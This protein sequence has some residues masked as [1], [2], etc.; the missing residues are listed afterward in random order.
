MARELVTKGSRFYCVSLT[1]DICK[2]PIGASTPPIPYNIIGEFSEATG[3]SPNITSN[4][5]PVALHDST[6]IPTVKGD[7]PGTAKG[8]KSGTV[9]KRVQH[10]GKSGTVTFNGQQAIRV[11]DRVYM[12]DKNTIGQV[13][14]RGPGPDEAAMAA[15]APTLPPATPTFEDKFN[16]AM[17]RAATVVRTGEDWLTGQIGG[18]A[19]T[20]AGAAIMAT[21][22]AVSDATE[23][24]PVKEWKERVDKDM[25]EAADSNGGSAMGVA[26]SLSH[27]ALEFIPT[28]M[29]DL[30]PGGGR[31]ASEAGKAAR[32]AKAA[33]RAERAAADA[34]KAAAEAERVAAAGRAA[35]GVT[36]L[37]KETPK[38]PRM[39]KD[40]GTSSGRGKKKKNNKP[41]KCC[42]KN[43]AP[44]GKSASS[45]HPVHFGTGEEVLV[46]T[47]FVLEGAEPIAWTRTYRSGSETEDWGLL[48]AR[49]GS[50]YTSS[51]HSC[52]QGIVYS[53]DSGRA[54]RLPPLAVGQTHDSREEGFTLVR[55][56]T[57]QFQL[58]WRDG[59]IDTFRQVADGWLPH[60][61]DG[62]NAMLRPQ[63]AQRTERFELSRSAGRDG[64][65]L[66]VE[67]TPPGAAGPLLLRVRGDDGLTLEAMAA[68]QPAPRFRT[69]ADAPAPQ[70]I[71]HVDQV[72]ADGSRLCLVT[73][74]YAP[75]SDAAPAV[76]DDTD[77]DFATLPQ[78]HN[79]VAQTNALGHTRRYTYRYHLLTNYTS[80][81]GHAHGLQWI[82]L[83][84]L[85]ARW[86]GNRLSAPMLAELLPI[87][88]DNS[89]QARATATT[90]EDGSD[91]TTID[92]VD[93]DT[94]RVTE[95]S[96]AVLVYTFDANWLVTKVARVPADGGLPKPLGA[97]EWDNDGMLLRESNAAGIGSHYDY[98]SA[99]NLTGSTDP[100]G[101]LSQI[102]YD[103]HNQ[104]VAVVDALGN[105]STQTYDDAGRLTNS[106]DALG[107]STAYHYDDKGRLATL[108][109]AKGGS[110]RFQYDRMGRL[111]TYTDCSG[112]ATVYH[113]DQQGRLANTVDEID[114]ET[115]YS[116][117]A[118]G[119]LLRVTQPDGTSETYTY[120]ADGNLLAHT[121]AAG[122]QTHYRY[123]GHGLP[124]QRTDALG[125]TLQYRYDNALRLAE[126]TNASGEIYHF[127]Y[128]DEGWLTSETGFDGKPTVYNYDSAGQLTGSDSLGQRIKL[129]HD[130]RGL[131]RSKTTASGI[132]RYDYDALG[133][134]TAVTSPEAAL[135]FRHDALGQL[136]EESSDYFLTTPEPGF[137]PKPARVPDATFVLQHVYDELG[138]RIQ[139]T[140]PNGRR[141]DTL[142]YG[143]GHWHGTLLDGETVVEIERDRLHRETRRL[144]GNGDARLVATRS[145]DRQSRLTEM[146][147]DRAG[148]HAGSHKIRERS[149]KYD[150]VGN[151]T[152]IKHGWHSTQETLGDFSYTYDPLGQLLSAV[153]PDLT[154]VFAFDPAGNL[155]DPPV[156]PPTDPWRHQHPPEPYEKTRIARGWAPARLPTLAQNL[157]KR[158]LG[159]SYE[160]DA[161]GNMISKYRTESRSPYA[162]DDLRLT[163]D[164]QNR[165]V[166]A[167]STRY[168]S[169][170]TAKYQYDAFSR[171]ISK[172]V[173]VEKWDNAR[174]KEIDA[175]KVT[176]CEA[177]LFVWIGNSLTQ[178]LRS[179]GSVTYL[180]EPNSFVPIVRIEL[181]EPKS[182][183]FF[184]C[185]KS[186]PIN[187]F[188]DT[189]A[190]IT[191]FNC[192]QLGTPK[193]LL[194]TDGKVLW[195][196]NNKAWGKSL[197][198][199]GESN[200]Q[201]FRFQG[202][203]HDNETGLQYNRN[204]YYDQDSSKYLTIDPIGIVGGL[205]PYSYAPNPTGWV[206]PSGLTKCIYTLYRGDSRDGS[207]IMKSH[208]ATK[209]G[210]AE[211]NAR[212]EL[213]D[214]KSMMKDHAQDSYQFFSPF[215]SLTSNPKVAEYFATNGGTRSGY[216][217]EFKIPCSRVIENIYN[218]KA[219]FIDGKYINEN[220]WLVKNYIKKSEIINKR[221]VP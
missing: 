81:G 2:T 142:R 158:Y 172:H 152:D 97:R 100:A 65:G 163:Y 74:Q 133:R 83:E 77:I 136:I 19:S 184:F 31:A 134:M 146:T 148:K 141:I 212:I 41:S 193:E 49:W 106:T 175:A 194:N 51:L 9:G 154:E 168:Q 171:R 32:I 132:V 120:D 6:V 84:A 63:P 156:Q 181:K 86:S 219:V 14:L 23:L 150:K 117:D 54:L 85:R 198:Y 50:P 35:G 145:Y 143:S 200:V 42:P 37:G 4:G 206:D 107:H 207:S 115:G 140:L 208:G 56:K 8:V 169:R 87:T 46:Q 93:D 190:N 39:G 125:Q 124:T 52:E 130:N 215:I 131:L 25:W 182:D 55:N 122:H 164:D 13:Y 121:D 218:R 144:L 147:L 29:L 211:A 108:V 92:Y 95:A 189:D 110:K 186:I 10:D 105:T 111:R 59:S 137:G 91:Q 96:G 138:H 78:R 167:V 66:S 210:Y 28:S 34:A 45:R 129:F 7:A 94:T 162:G 70:R 187:G 103:E 202:Q 191:Y 139:T 18:F 220:E 196:R 165:L 61:Y 197:T 192:D 109:D 69:I 116:Y 188:K 185:G 53:D 44:A 89:Y 1:P 60:G 79:L 57:E 72:F 3:V 205:N 183:K 5:E 214:M 203:Y 151:L 58:T 75:E 82:S 101:N 12:N 64:R 119:Q 11:G 99:G 157:I 149:F 114:N 76:A 173:T 71:D 15:S 195:N 113:Y 36:K 24:T 221:K 159:Y 16:A 204:R 135:R 48:G 43:A 90:T 180:Y 199:D 128:N 126:L 216:V 73:Y 21:L 118:I 88:L 155:V 177:T 217:Y 201:N 209:Y 213:G 153:Q 161:Q 47:D 17:G 102:A 40:G 179:G 62:A 170:Y 26:A 123:N 30:L 112:Y 80:Y 20:K 22:Q 33:A 67:R 38:P 68:P 178:E 160:Y 27:A 127:T 166:R 104:P 174:L 98:D 176:T